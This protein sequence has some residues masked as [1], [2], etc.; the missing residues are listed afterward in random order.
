MPQSADQFAKALIAAGLSS[1]EEVKSFWN[2]LPAGTRPKDGTAFAQALIEQSKLTKFQA[3]ELLSGSQTPLVLGDYVLLAKIGAGGMGQVFQAEHRHMKRLAAI[4]LLPAALTKDEAAV[5]RFQREVQAAAKLSHPNIVQTFDAGVQKGVWY[6]VMEYVAGR[7]LS[8]VVAHE[9]PLPV[10]RAV[11]YIRQAA[12]GLAFAHSKG[13]VHRDIKPANLLLDQDGTVKIL[14]MGL[15]RFDDGAAAAQDGLTQSGQVMGTVDY[16]APEQAFNTRN[17][18]ARADIYSLGCTLYRLLT[19]KNLFDGETLVEK[20]M[21]HQSKPVPSLAASRP[22][23]PAALVKIFE[24]MVAKRPEDRFQ[25]M[26]EVESALAQLD[27]SSPAAGTSSAAPSSSSKLSS[28]F[29]SLGTKPA[30]AATAASVTSAAVAEK[31]QPAVT[32]IDGVS[33]TVALVNPLHT[34]DPVSQ[35]TIDVAR[36][37]TPQPSQAKRPPI[38]RQP[39]V[40]AAGGLGAFLLLALGIWVIVRD[41]DGKEVARVKVPEGGTA[42]V[43]T[44]ENGNPSQPIKPIGNAPPLAVAP[45]DAQ[46]ARAH[47]EAWAK[48]LGLPVEKEVTLPGGEKIAFLLIPAGEFLMGSTADEQT[49]FLKDAQTDNV[50][51]TPEFKWTLDHISSEG[52]QHRVRITK[53]FYLAKYE[54]TQAQWQAVMG[55]NPSHFKG[56][57]THPVDSI[58]WDD[59]EP[60]LAKL[61]S[62]ARSGEMTFAL[63][64]Q[65]QWEYACRAGSTSVWQHGDQVDGLSSHAWFKQNSD[66]TTHAVGALQPNA[67]GLYDMH[68][69]VWEWCADWFAADY[70][71]KS[72]T[73]D[74]RASSRGPQRVACG[75]AWSEVA[76]F[77]RSA[78]RTSS[79]PNLRFNDGGARLALV[80]NERPTAA[81]SKN[82]APPPGV[83]APTSA[84]SP[85]VAPFDAKAAKAHQEVWA[86]HL[87]TQVE[88]TN[89]VGQKMILIPPG[90]FLMGSTDEQVTAAL[91]VAQEIK[92][93]QGV[94]D[95]I[96][97][98]ERPQHKVVITKPLL[99]SATEV[100]V[101]QFKKFA[102]ATGYQTEA[103]KESTAAKT[104][105]YLAATSDDLP[106]AYI[107]WNDATAYCQWLS[108]QEKTTYRLPTEAEWEYACRAGTTTQYSFGDDVALLNQYGWSKENADG[109]SHPVGTLL[110]NPFG[111]FD[112]HG[113]SYEWCGD[114]YDEKWYGASPP[115]DPNGPSVGSTRVTRGGSWLHHAS[116]CRSAYRNYLSPSSR[117]NNSGFRCVSVIDMPA[118][119]PSGIASTPPV[120]TSP[121]VAKPIG[122]APPLAKAP[123]D[124][125]KARAHQEAWAKHLGVPVEYTNSIG[126]KF[127]LIPPGEFMMGSTP[128]EIEAALKGVDQKLF[129]ECI[130]SESP[131]HKVILTQPFY[132][133]VNEVTQAEYEKVMGTN[134]S[135]FS[136]RGMGKEAVAGLETTEH[137]VEQVSWNDAAEFCAKLS[138]QE[139]LKPFYFR[140]GETITPLDG[141]GYRLPSEAE[142]E[143]AGRAGTVTKY[144]IGDQNEDLVRGGWFND[145]SGSRTHAAGE[146]K[147]NPFGLT[148]IHGNVWEWVQDGWDASYY[149]Q[150][151]EKTAIDPNSPFFASSQRVIRGGDWRDTASGCRSSS[152]SPGIPSDRYFRIG[153]RVSL[154]VE[155]V[156]QQLAQKAAT[157]PSPAIAPYDAKTAR[158][159]QE[160]WAK[161]LGI[162]VETPNSVGQTMILIPPGEFLMGSSDE[163]VEAA[164]KLAE[165]IN[166][167]RG[168]KDRIQKSERPQ[169]RVVITKPLLMSATE[170]TIGQFKKF[171]AATG[172]Q[173]E[174][175]KAE[176]AAKA[177]PPLVEAG[178][179]PP[180]PTLTYLSPGYAVTDDSPAAMI[181]WNDA[182]AYCQWLSTQEKATYR[183]PTEAEW[184]YASRAGT[185]TQYSFG[186]DNH[187][188][189]KYGW[190]NQNAA[191][192]SH[193]IGTLLPNNFGL[194]DMH[195]NLYEWCGD[196]F[197]EKWY[198]TSPLNDPNGPSFGSTRVIRG[199]SWNHLA[200]HCRSAYRHAN[201][202]S[203]RAI[204]LGF[205]VARVLD[206]PSTRVP[207]VSPTTA[208]VVYLDDL[209]EKSY[210]GLDNYLFKPG[211]NADDAAAFS[212]VFVSE[213][214]VHTLLMHPPPAQDVP[215]MT[216]RAVYDLAAGYSR[217]QAQFRVRALKRSDPIW[218]EVWGDGKQLWASGDLVPRKVGGETADIDVR[219]VRELTLVVRAEKDV[220]SAHTLL[221][222]PRLTAVAGPSSSPAGSWKIVATEPADG[223]A[224]LPVQ[225]GAPWIGHDGLTL[226]GNNPG[227]DRDVHLATRQ[228]AGE[229]WSQPVNLGPTVNS[230]GGLNDAEDSYATLAQ[231]R[232]TLVFFSKRS[233]AE[234]LWIATRRAATDPFEPPTRLGSEIN[235]HG[236]SR[237]WFPALSADGRW[238]TYARLSSSESSRG[239]VAQRKEASAEFASVRPLGP[240]ID[241]LGYMKWTTLTNDG[242]TLAAVVAEGRLPD[243]PKSIWMATRR[244]TDAPFENPVE[245]GPEF[246]GTDLCATLSG[247]GHSLWVIRNGA[248][249]RA[250]RAPVAANSSPAGR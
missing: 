233:P 111:L 185:T 17:A 158:S 9:G 131:Q 141:T 40:L 127:R 14:D 237:S 136:P 217:F 214:P 222:A 120:V 113:N 112:M 195:G 199:G 12:K 103:E 108:T 156:K 242:L 110:P 49:R 239:F 246:R 163:Q 89:S 128:K 224:K 95:R 124:A 206:I 64:T 164:L 19:G 176:A 58:N 41:K 126:M 74:P 250:E 91:K 174:A 1:T 71:S 51:S 107:T 57:P 116:Y 97:T 138:Q 83:P 67:F 109:K 82:F 36:Q 201:Q 13:V 151:S 47:Q 77:C 188:L 221:I 21:A 223:P 153:F 202:P 10:A 63:P 243:A 157:T 87:G 101:G 105:T 69:N 154:V 180:M 38:W 241:A 45:F 169:H 148:D 249:L 39:L 142:W 56:H 60:F 213:S 236:N 190:H 85:A 84:P 135:H 240:A 177:A 212:K 178:Q 6:L 232:L 121:P 189:S 229:A 16:M 52:P 155:S 187:E 90:E 59:L 3:Q 238:L 150:F 28:F 78:M 61:N 227:T 211:R 94:K 144:W 194:F 81:N 207:P 88:T 25:T 80:I 209:I 55:S 192:K 197:D 44:T 234:G 171:A 231:D 102:A 191:A 245:L 225:L 161:H 46:Q 168:T 72:P 34:T 50:A 123:F 200:S 205:R 134:P 104:N 114:Y 29:Q 216:S 42:T 166:A 125:A 79:L 218:A 219:G 172:Y 37:N 247:D 147:A 198:S 210:V 93:D 32:V 33:P 152:R 99:M 143:F 165:E 139:K 182:V 106:A 181:I 119:T 75:G 193:P 179:P 62:D 53:P 196:Y 146:L 118:T 203:H 35:R 43:E 18:D 48:Y 30:A 2:A 235:A 54:L 228:R 215:D 167:D 183:L 226:L 26:A 70:Y 184:E 170:V 129:Q 137:P 140:A 159:H 130:N 27:G 162:Q 22:D 76:A 186:D 5:K 65:A 8:G 15:A 132:L 92:A 7:D 160:A 122:P 98:A 220:T 230:K 66:G 244:T 31:T 24:R 173:T 73:D 133:G 96:E 117:S 11:D 100:T 23:V 175:E 86:K 248:L 149:S 145:N 68:G 4:K 20:L 115:N 208:G 204:H